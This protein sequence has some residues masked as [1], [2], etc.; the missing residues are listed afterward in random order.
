MGAFFDG[1]CDTDG[2]AVVV[3]V[4]EEVVLG[5]EFRLQLLRDLP[6]AQGGR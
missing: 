3:L 2:L 5:L 1:G 4:E 6:L